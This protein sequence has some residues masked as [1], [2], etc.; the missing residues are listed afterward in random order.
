MPVALKIFMSV[1]DIETITQH[2]C[3]PEYSSKKR[4]SLDILRC[5]HAAIY[6]PILL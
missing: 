5:L 3:Y 2:I 4:G 1:Y 6:S